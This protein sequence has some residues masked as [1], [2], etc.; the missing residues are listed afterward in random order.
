VSRQG[1]TERAYADSE[2]Y[3]AH[4]ARAVVGVGPPLEAGDTLL[5]LACG[6]GAFAE[7]LPAGVR[8]LGVDSSSE[9]GD[10]ARARGH[11]V[12][13]ADLNVFVPSEPVAVTT[14]FRAIYYARDRR[15][16]FAHVAGYTQKKLVFDLNPRQ[17]DLQSVIAD[18]RSAGFL[19]VVIRPFFSPQRVA[20]PSP[21]A[22]GLRALEGVG[23]VARLL[24]RMRFT[25]ICAATRETQ[26]M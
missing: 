12:V 20:L 10:A 5:D 19:R 24:L 15:R 21:V 25:Y 26:Q 7:Y 4:R 17:Y 11:D 3:L 6:D 1:W 14:C 23:P 8:Y 2:A 16:F 18:L 22:S 13:V 9:M